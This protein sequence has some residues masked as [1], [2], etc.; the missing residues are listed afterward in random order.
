MKSGKFIDR[1]DFIKP[2]IVWELNGSFLESENTADFYHGLPFTPLIIGEYSWN[3]DFS[4]SRDFSVWKTDGE[5]FF[6]GA[7]AS[8]VRFAMRRSNA[9]NRRV[10]IRA[11]GIAPPNYSQEIKAI[12]AKDK[13]DSRKRMLKIVS[14]GSFNKGDVIR[15]NLGYSPMVYFWANTTIFRSGQRQY[16][17][18]ERC[19]RPGTYGVEIGPRDIKMNTEQDGYY[20]L[21][22]EPINN[23]DI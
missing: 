22:A 3:S 11:I 4:D 13:Y 21:T 17:N 18:M 5:N 6:V 10:Y 14:F 7:L 20:I 19:L 23:E 1:S 16:S 2:V 12:P 15:H 9:N 8:S